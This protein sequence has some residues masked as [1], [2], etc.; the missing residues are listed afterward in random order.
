MPES[1]T[2]TVRSEVN[3]LH[4]AL[5]MRLR[6]NQRPL[7]ATSSR[8]ITTEEVNFGGKFAKNYLNR[9]TGRLQTNKKKYEDQNGIVSEQLIQESREWVIEDSGGTTS[10]GSSMS[11]K[12][13]VKPDARK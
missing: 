13:E 6:S 4:N 5:S 2:S 10:E 9:V 3:F 12:S 8:C 11:K 1:R 7:L